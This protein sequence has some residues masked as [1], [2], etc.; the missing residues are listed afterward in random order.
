MTS[1]VFRSE[2]VRVLENEKGVEVVVLLTFC[3]Q[4]KECYS[5]IK[6]VD[7][8]MVSSPQWRASRQRKLSGT[9]Q[10]KGHRPRNKLGVCTTVAQPTT[11]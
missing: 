7:P 2:Q 10:R 4:R 6:E 3:V 9:G 8:G 1:T 11:V 5:R